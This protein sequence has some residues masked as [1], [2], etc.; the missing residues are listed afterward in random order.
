MTLEQRLV[1]EFCIAMDVPYANA[2]EVP[3]L[4]VR[5]LRAKLCAEESAE[6]AVA[7]G[8]GDLVEIADALADLL[9]V[10]YGAALACGID[11][12]PIFHAVHQSNM[13]KVGG[14]KRADG[15]VLKPATYQPPNLVPLL[16]AQGMP[17]FEAITIPLATGG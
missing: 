2:P 7:M 1:R 10:T 4:E 15:K 6:L 5:L 14:E 8:R 11:L 17:E 13:T 16:E 3:S 12:Q 9:Y